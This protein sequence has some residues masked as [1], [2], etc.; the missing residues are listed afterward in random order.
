MEHMQSSSCFNNLTAEKNRKN[1]C[2]LYDILCFDGL[3]DENNEKTHKPFNRKHSDVQSA[4]LD[5][6]NPLADTKL[7][8]DS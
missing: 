2:L 6:C 5:F 1:F 8:I 7:Y 4:V 3:Q